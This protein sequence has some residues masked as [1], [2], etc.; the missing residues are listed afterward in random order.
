VPDLRQR[1]CRRHFLYFSRYIDG[2]CNNK[3]IVAAHTLYLIICVTRIIFLDTLFFDLLSVYCVPSNLSE[4]TISFTSYKDTLSLSLS[5]FFSRKFNWKVDLLSQVK[6]KHKDETKWHLL[7]D[8][9][10]G[11]RIIFI[12]GIQEL[13]R[14]S[15]GLWI[16]EVVLK[17]VRFSPRAP[18]GEWRRLT[19]HYESSNLLE[20]IRLPAIIFGDSGRKTLLINTE[21]YIVDPRESLKE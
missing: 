11:A 13:L 18:H 7:R 21:D 19:R 10:S 12:S 8:V 14:N 1:N 6:A 3:F 17:D 15:W 20:W 4:E 16:H 9:I 2:N 5:L